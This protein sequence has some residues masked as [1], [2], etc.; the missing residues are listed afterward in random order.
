MGPRDVPTGVCGRLPWSS[1]RGE[2]SLTIVSDLGNLNLSSWNIVFIFTSRWRVCLLR[3]RK[4]ES[5]YS[6]LHLQV[7]AAV[8]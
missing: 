1:V 5:V 2:L 7:F 3:S 4:M 8:E 6:S